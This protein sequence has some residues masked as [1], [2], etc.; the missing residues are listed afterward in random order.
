MRVFIRTIDPTIR[1]ETGERFPNGK[2]MSCGQNWVEFQ[3]LIKACLLKLG[4]TVVEQPSHP[5]VPDDTV[6]ADFRI[7]A[8]KTRRDVDGN[9]FYKQM[10]LSDLFTLDHEGWGADHSGMNSPPPFDRVEA[11]VAFDFCR[12]LREELLR[13]GLS[14]H[15]QPPRNPA[16]DLT[17]GYLFVPLQRPRDYVQIHHSRIT[18]ID[19]IHRVVDWADSVRQFVAIKPHP[20]NL[21]DPDVMEAVEGRCRGSR[22]AI[23]VNGNVHDLI[24]GSL[25]VFA[26]NSG[27]GFESLIHGKPVVTFGDADYTWVTYRGSADRLDEALHYSSAY[28]D[29]QRQRAW[30]FLY[31]YVFEHGYSLGEISRAEC[32]RRLCAYLEHRLAVAFQEPLIRGSLPTG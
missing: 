32:K 27:V 21:Y 13:T 10:H 19:F 2:Q 1:L 7:Y 16:L 8:H 4:H 3:S 18:V 22:Y 30:Q 26:I 28:T 15:P 24:S 5:R 12:R 31:Y 9:L 29:S 17:P 14:K 23:L 20:G 11:K 6:E 25:G